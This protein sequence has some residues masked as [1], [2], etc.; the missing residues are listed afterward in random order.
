MRIAYQYRFNPNRGQVDELEKCLVCA[1]SSLNRFL[2]LEG[3]VNRYYNRTRHEQRIIFG[4]GPPCFDLIIFNKREMVLSRILVS[5]WLDKQWKRTLDWRTDRWQGQTK[6]RNEF[7][8]TTTDGTQQRQWW[9]TKRRFG[10]KQLDSYIWALKISLSLSL[11]M[12]GVAMVLVPSWH[13][14]MNK[15]Y[16]SFHNRQMVDNLYD[17][18]LR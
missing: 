7:L 4:N 13:G 11:G 12:M 9:E 18:L 8:S 14:T 2:W 1:A 3:I 5:A 10:T 16:A 6:T 15:S 17:Q